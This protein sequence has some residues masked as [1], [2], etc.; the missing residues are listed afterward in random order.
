MNKTVILLLLIIYSSLT[1]SKAQPFLLKSQTKPSFSFKIYYGSKGKG[2]FVQYTGQKGIIPLRLKSYKRDSTDRE[3]GQPDEQVYFWDEIVD[4][5]MSGTYSLREGLRYITDAWYLRG[6]DNRKFD[7]EEPKEKEEYDGVGK[8]LLHGTL[9]EFNHF[10]NDTL[11]FRYP[12]KTVSVLI[13]PEIIQPGGARQSHIA[14][15]NFDGYDDVGFSVTDAGMGVY[16]QYTIYLYNPK[17]QQFY[18]LQE[19]EYNE[20]IK[21]SCLCDVT[22]DEKKKELRTSC[23]GGARWWHDVWRFK[24]SKLEWV[25]SKAEPPEN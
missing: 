12:N 18:K 16:Q 23:R 22:V 13:L 20:K 11:I 4:G 19:P 9:I 6:R 1:Q 2:A 24:N 8:Y 21:C 15:Y 25:S 7:L 3:Y 5:K 10:Y 14:D 17:Y